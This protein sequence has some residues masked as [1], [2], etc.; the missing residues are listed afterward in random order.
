MNASKRLHVQVQD[1][2]VLFKMAN[3]FLTM[4]VLSTFA[5]WK[6]NAN[7]SLSMG[8]LVIVTRKMSQI[9]TVLQKRRKFARVIGGEDLFVDLV[10]V[11]LLKDST[12]LALLTL[13]FVVAKPI[14]S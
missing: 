5:L 9:N 11:R 4:P 2:F 3:V 1:V 6:I 10:S 13:E 14:I 8:T 12:N 7:Q